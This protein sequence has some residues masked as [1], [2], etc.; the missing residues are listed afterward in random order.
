[1]KK[2]FITFLARH[3][4]AIV[5]ISAAA[6]VAV[7]LTKKTKIMDAVNN[8]VSNAK[9]EI[10]ILSL[11][12]AIR[13]K[14]RQFINAAEAAGINLLITSG[15]RSWENQNE[16][17]A[18]GRTKAGKIVT[19]AKGGQSFHNYGL[20]I[21]VVPLV[22]GAADW[23]TNRWNEIAAIA[24]KYGFTWGGDFTNIVDK[25]HF[26][27]SAGLTLAQLQAKFNTGQLSGGFV[28]LT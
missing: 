8:T 7:A 18:Q 3:Q 27:Y 11:H 19:N 22:N 26:Q 9:N 4:W 17:Y 21:D 23:N 5:A 2:N 24:K 6:L 10:K 13:E 12:P 1:M 25:P 28:N 20:A 14:V 15:F 16:L